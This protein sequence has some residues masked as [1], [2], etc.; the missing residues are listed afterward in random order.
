MAHSDCRWMCGCAGKTE[1]LWERFWGDD[2]RR[3]T[4]SIKCTYLYVYIYRQ[5]QIPRNR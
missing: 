1:I 5:W 4:I 2:S 3:G